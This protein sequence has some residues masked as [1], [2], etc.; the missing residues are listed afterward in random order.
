MSAAPGPQGEGTPMSTATQGPPQER[1]AAPESSLDTLKSIWRE[2]PGLVSDRVELLSLE[3]H[4]AGRALLQI[5]VLGIALAALGITAWVI[6][7]G[8]VIT[9]LTQA[10]VPGMVVLLG[11]LTVHVLLGAWVVH[12]V[13]KLLPML[14]LPATRRRLMFSSS[15]AQTPSSSAEGPPKERANHVPVPPSQSPSAS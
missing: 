7:W 3:L 6:L 1:G 8:L 11:A 2:L 10:G 9:G 13:K 14:G 4:W 12:R 5:V 15:P